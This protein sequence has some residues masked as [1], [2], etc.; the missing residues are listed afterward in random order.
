MVVDK[1]AVNPPAEEAEG[2]T[3]PPQ[4]MGRFVSDVSEKQ[5]L[6]QLDSESQAWKRLPS[7]GILVSGHDLLALPAF[8][9]LIALT[10]GLTI[11]LRGGT[12]INLEAVD[13]R[14]TPR[15]ALKF[16]RIVIGRVSKSETRLLLNL[17]SQP[18]T[19]VF[20]DPESR[21]A[22]EMT[23]TLTPGSNP[24]RNPAVPVVEIYA[25]SGRLV[26]E[27]EDGLS[28]IEFK[29][30][31]R[32]TLGPTGLGPAEPVN[33]FPR[34]YVSDSIDKL[35]RSASRTLEEA[36]LVDRPVTL[37][38]K[39]E[40]DHRKVEVRRLA[41]QS[42]GFVGDFGPL[43]SAL[44][45][46]EEKLVWTWA[47]HIEELRD[48]L[49][50]GPDVAGQVRSALEEAFGPKG[51]KLY[52]MLWGYSPQQLVDERQDT[53]LV[54]SLSDDL[55]AVRVVSFWNLND[56]TGARLYYH[57]TDTP[58]KRQKA[59]RVWERRLKDGEI[60]GKAA[61]PARPSPPPTSPA[62]VSPEEETPVSAKPTATLPLSAVS[63]P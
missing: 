35:S 50:R 44:D 18:G 58:I 36:I 6:L 12:Q 63:S 13:E 29:T 22:V 17:G 26:W 54:E 5:L 48:A 42:L 32:L 1:P 52:R 7:Q 62:K 53:E 3:K 37:G 49:A 33:E 61:V 8:R 14:E 23:R 40:L 27:T 51:P 30:P 38:L 57:P 41:A 19:L 39:E 4:H 21:A 34:W 28:K 24:E 60:R 55:L 47:D 9:P 56:I 10:A 59:I 11:Q 43:V 15:V 31:S 25:L 46:P 20:V 2:A 45:R 16:G